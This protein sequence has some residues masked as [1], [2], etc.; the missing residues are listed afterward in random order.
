MS[1][2]IHSTSL[3]TEL[4]EIIISFSLIQN[5]RNLLKTT[6]REGDINCL[7]GLRFISMSWVILGHSFFF[8]VS[9]IGTV[10]MGLCWVDCDLGDYVVLR[11]MGIALTR[12][13][14]ATS[15]SGESQPFSNLP[16]QLQI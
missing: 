7:H 2:S 1:T 10:K 3:L 16:T 6:Q 15:W 8:M 13:K 14:P 12:F 9:F 4:S 5:T 11:D